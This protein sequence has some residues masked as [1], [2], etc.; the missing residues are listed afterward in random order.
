[1]GIEELV[2]YCGR[3]DLGAL[4]KDPETGRLINPR[5]S[6]GRCGSNQVCIPY[7]PWHPPRPDL[8][9]DEEITQNRNEL[10]WLRKERERYGNQLPLRQ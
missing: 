3:E 6:C 1:M 7:R 2:D 9:L 10:S 8:S 4:V 5:I